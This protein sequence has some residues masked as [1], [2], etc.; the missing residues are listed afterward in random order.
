MLNDSNNE[1]IDLTMDDDEE[2]EESVVPH[3]TYF[4]PEEIRNHISTALP[5]ICKQKY[6]S[7]IRFL[8]K[9]NTAVVFSGTLYNKINIVLRMIGYRFLISMTDE[10][11]KEES[12]KCQLINNHPQFFPHIF[13]VGIMKQNKNSYYLRYEIQEFIPN[14]PF[15][16]TK[17]TLDELY[18]FLWTFW[19][20]G[21]THG[22]LTFRN[23]RYNHH[24]WRLIDISNVTYNNPSLLRFDFKSPCDFYHRGIG[25]RDHNQFQIMVDITPEWK[26]ICN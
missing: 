3:P 2:N 15:P 20:S 7:D 13:N 22:D 23:L 8:D 16:K 19:S 17:Q 6:L 9:G 24:T 1:V 25:H 21:F 10:E 12:M 4:T 14:E 5:I 18:Q 26:T 11:R